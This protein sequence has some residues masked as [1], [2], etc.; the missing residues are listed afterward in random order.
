LRILEIVSACL[1]SASALCFLWKGSRSRAARLLLAAA[2]LALILHG[3]IEGPHWQMA[4]AYLAA[5]LLVAAL[6]LQKR[7]LPRLLSVFALLLVAA[8]VLCSHILPM[9][10]LPKPD[11]PFEVG[12]RIFNLTDP[13]R[14]EPAPAG[15]KRE[16]IVQAWYPARCAVTHSALLRH[17]FPYRGLAPYRRS[18]E[19]TLLSSYQR[20]V[21][22]NSCENGALAAGGPFPILLFS[23]AIDGRRTQSTFL[24]EE[25]ASYGFA[26]FSLDHPYSTGPVE[27]ADGRVLDTPPSPIQPLGQI[28][29]DRAYQILNALVDTQ[30]ADTVFVLNTLEQWNRDPSNLFYGRLDTARVGTLGHSLGGSVAAE[31]AVVDPRIR[32]VFDMSGPLLSQARKTG[33]TV[34]FFFMTEHVPL[35]STQQLARL[36]PDARVDAEMDVADFKVLVP[37]MAAHGEYYAELP[38]G[39]HAA[40]TDRPSFSPYVRFGGSDPAETAR[41]DPIIRRYAVAFFQQTLL[42]EPS[43]L[44]Q[45]QPSPYPGVQFYKTRE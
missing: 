15:G 22:T 28:G 38:T 6:P 42:G 20:F 17:L 9:F 24:M 36:Q 21:W 32:A 10:T 34:P 16:V 31:T 13:T 19:T 2:F 4:P 12:T 39:N 30:T 7:L 40:F 37:M 43:P 3:L 45:Q 8:A 35:L 27:L 11:G 25:L 23:P 5:L 44:L 18:K 26:V 1:L 41:L 33:V 29:F 14:Q